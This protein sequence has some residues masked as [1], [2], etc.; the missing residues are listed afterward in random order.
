MLKLVFSCVGHLRFRGLTSRGTRQ[1]EPERS[2][3]PLPPRTAATFCPLTALSAPPGAGAPAQPPPGS[4]PLRVPCAPGTAPAPAS[5]GR[6]GCSEG[7]PRA[8]WEDCTGVWRSSPKFESQGGRHR[9]TSR[10]GLGGEEHAV[11]LAAQADLVGVKDR[12]GKRLPSAGLF[13]AS[14]PATPS[15]LRCAGVFCTMWL[16]KLLESHW[17]GLSFLKREFRFESVIPQ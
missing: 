13:R 16:I 2:L 10:L 17:L 3:S 11:D 5:R 8:F 1:A 9:G 7:I 12:R 15:P 6:P 4:R 14:S